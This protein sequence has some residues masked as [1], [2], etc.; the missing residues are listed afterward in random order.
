MGEGRA[1]SIQAALE[2]D[3][4]PDQDVQEVVLHDPPTEA[5]RR[6]SAALDIINRLEQ[7]NQQLVKEVV[8]LREKLEEGDPNADELQRMNAFLMAELERERVKITLTSDSDTVETPG[9]DTGAAGS[10]VVRVVRWLEGLWRR[11]R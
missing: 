1:V 11:W 9:D 3:E 4:T 2:A 10:T 5:L 8:A 6:L 7:T